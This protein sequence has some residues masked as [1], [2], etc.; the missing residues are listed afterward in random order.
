MGGRPEISKIS[1]S[2]HPTLVQPYHHVP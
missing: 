1:T 2:T